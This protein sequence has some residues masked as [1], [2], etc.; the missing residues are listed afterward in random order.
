[1]AA[2]LR[3]VFALIEY[4]PTIEMKMATIRTV[5]KDYFFKAITMLCDSTHWD[6]KAG[7]VMKYLRIMRHVIKTPIDR[8]YEEPNMLMHYEWV[9]H[10]IQKA[11]VNIVT[12]MKNDIP[13]TN[14]DKVRNYE[15]SLM[16]FTL[17]K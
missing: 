7:I 12:K 15:I 11:L 17:V 16:I 6:E 1:M 13:L 3:I 10:V 14:G 4:S 9:A 8:E 5:R 2:L